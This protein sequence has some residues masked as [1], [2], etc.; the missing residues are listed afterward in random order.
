MLVKSYWGTWNSRLT[1]VQVYNFGDVEAR[2]KDEVPDIKA[3]YI[4]QHWDDVICVA[5]QRWLNLNFTTLTI[6][7]T[8]IWR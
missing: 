6:D 4:L 1:T 5:G 3:S 8:N 2:S 7:P